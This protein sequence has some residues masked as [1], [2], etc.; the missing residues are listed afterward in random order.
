MVL[1]QA[2]HNPVPFRPRASAQNRS[3]QRMAITLDRGQQIE[4]G[5]IGESGFDAIDTFH[6]AQQFIVIENGCARIFKFM[7]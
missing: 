7:R 1:D 4:A 5:R 6:P 3:H 2:F